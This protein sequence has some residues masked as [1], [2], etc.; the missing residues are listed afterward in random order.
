MTDF[1]YYSRLASN[2]GSRYTGHK[3]NGS[4]SKKCTLLTDY[5]T[6]KEKKGMNGPMSSYRMKSPMVWAE[7]KFMPN[8]L[9]KTYLEYLKSTYN[10][11]IPKIAAMLGIA[12]ITLR[13]YLDLHDLNIFELHSLMSKDDLLNWEVFLNEKVS[14]MPDIPV[15]QPKEAEEAWSIVINPEEKSD[16]VPDGAGHGGLTSFTLRF[17]GRLDIPKV[18]QTINGILGDQPKGTLEIVYSGKETE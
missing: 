5:M 12:P 2:R 18:L 8:D 11:T 14:A 4:K 16:P 3:K 13:K 7:F 10:A 17:E 6:Q 1:Q 15:E 9:Q